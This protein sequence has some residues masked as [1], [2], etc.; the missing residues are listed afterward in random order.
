VGR[1]RW[2][3]PGAKGGT[4]DVDTREGRRDQ[5]RVARGGAR[6]MGFDFN[7]MANEKNSPL[8]FSQYART[9]Y[10]PIVLRCTT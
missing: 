2:K 7:P 6:M 3:L 5:W 10:N 1:E 8:Q 4:Y 9:E